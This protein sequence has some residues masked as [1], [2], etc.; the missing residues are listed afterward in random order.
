MRGRRHDIEI[1]EHLI[2]EDDVKRAHICF[3]Q[4][5]VRDLFY[6]AATQL[7][8]LALDGKPG[9]TVSEALAV[10]LRTWNS[11]FYRYRKFDKAHLERLERVYEKHKS[12]LGAYR[13]RTID[14]LEDADKTAILDLVRDF[15]NELYP[16]RSR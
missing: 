2:S 15:E 6:R 16:C 11:A 5:E 4:H 12:A 3:E 1:T 8:A 9:L 14:S 13:M 10:L 7:V